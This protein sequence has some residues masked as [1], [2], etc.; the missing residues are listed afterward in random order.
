MFDDGYENFLTSG[1]NICQR[2]QVK[3]TLAVIPSSVDQK[4]TGYA[5]KEQLE[6]YINAGGVIVPHYGGNLTTDFTVD[7]AKQ[8]IQ[9]TIQ[10]IR[11]NNLA[12]RN[13]DKTY[14]W[15]MA[16]YQNIVGDTKY[17]DMLSNLGISVCRGANKISV[18]TQGSVDSMSKWN[19]FA[20]P[21]IGHNF[22]GTTATE[23][24]NITSIVNEINACA[25]SGNMDVF[26]VLH[27][28][29]PNSTP[30]NDMTLS[31]RESD[32]ITICNA[33]KT[34][35]DAGLLESVSLTDFVS[36]NNPWASF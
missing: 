12:T 15:P 21:T 32:L 5:S 9:D 14:V 36:E 13:F 17:I 33:I 26:M 8:V 28:V 35:Q 30:D 20:L 25:T 31:I 3:S 24:T 1:F 16:R 34:Q 19:R 10:W 23:A 4:L 7:G 29:V 6:S 27:K 2:H 18:T 22:A 11:D